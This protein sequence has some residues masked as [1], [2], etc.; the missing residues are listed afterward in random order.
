MG[1]RNA[2]KEASRRDK[3]HGGKGEV[4]PAEEKEEPT[5]QKIEPRRKICPNTEL[6][7]RMVSDAD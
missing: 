7:M 2:N 6:S 3:N 1:E 4:P 5:S